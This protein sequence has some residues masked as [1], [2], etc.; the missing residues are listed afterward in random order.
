MVDTLTAEHCLIDEKFYHSREEA[1]SSRIQML[2]VD[3]CS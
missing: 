1:R 2:A 3:P